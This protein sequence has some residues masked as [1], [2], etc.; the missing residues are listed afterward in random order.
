MET[1]GVSP[2]CAFI[3][4]KENQLTKKVRHKRGKEENKQLQQGF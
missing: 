1:G 4:K 2:Y 3:N